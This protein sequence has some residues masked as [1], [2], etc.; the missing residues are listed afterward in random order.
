MINGCLGSFLKIANLKYLLLLIIPALILYSDIQFLE[1]SPNEDEIWF[2]NKT[3]PAEYKAICLIFNEK[4]WRQAAVTFTSILKNEPNFPFVFHIFNTVYCRNLEFRKYF[5]ETAQ[6][7]KSKV[8]FHQINDTK[9]YF[10]RFNRECGWPP[11]IMAKLYL[12]K[13]LSNEDKVLYLDADTLAVQ[14]ISSIFQYEFNI[15]GKYLAGAKDCGTYPKYWVNSGFIYYNLEKIRRDNQ[16]DKA[17]KCV[18]NCG[19]RYYD[20]WCHTR[21][22]PRKK[23]RIL[24]NRY[25]YNVNQIRDQE[26]RKG[27]AGEVDKLIV[28]HFM[29][30]SKIVFQMKNHSEIDEVDYIQRGKELMHLYLSYYIQVNETSKKLGIP[31]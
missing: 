23:V 7:T 3:V 11:L 2:F 18:H 24:P 10:P 28:A 9:L 31:E 22:F 30:R 12:S 27:I 6:R 1:T 17:L 21:C 25:N 20:D 13:Y 26:K 4:I 29:H 16:L 15:E 5:L 14:P 19:K 8:V